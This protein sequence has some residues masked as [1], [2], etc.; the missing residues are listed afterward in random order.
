MSDYEIGYG[1]PPKQKR[2]KKGQSGNPKGR[3][4]KAADAVS[5]DDAEILGR[6]DNELID[7]GGTQMSR[8][9]AEIRVILEMAFRRER[10]AVRLIEQLRREVQAT[11]GGGVMQLPL[12]HFLGDD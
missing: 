3:P 1:K 5:V 6:L 9:E 8:R 12:A 2:W 11:S 4:R 7:V 10:K